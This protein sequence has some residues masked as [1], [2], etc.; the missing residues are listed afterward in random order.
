[1]FQYVSWIA[2]DAVAWTLDAEGMAADP[3]TEISDRPIAQE[4]MVCA[5]PLQFLVILI[6]I[7]HPSVPHHELGHVPQLCQRRLH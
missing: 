2:N 3:V 7:K 6:L 5:L 1:M 4:P